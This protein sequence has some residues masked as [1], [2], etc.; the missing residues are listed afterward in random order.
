MV[1]DIVQVVKGLVDER[2]PRKK[3][4]SGSTA[5][6]SSTTPTSACWGSSVPSSTTVAVCPL[7]ARTTVWN[8]PSKS[9]VTG[10]LTL[11]WPLEPTGL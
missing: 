7:T 5:E 8:A 11:A 9:E 1:P 10:K 3:M 2:C 4:Q 6:Q